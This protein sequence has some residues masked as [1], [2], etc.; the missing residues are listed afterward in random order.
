MS[1]CVW[2]PP[3]WGPPYFQYAVHH[4]LPRLGRTLLSCQNS[5]LQWL[6]RSA[7][8]VGPGPN[9]GQDKFS[10][11]ATTSTYRQHENSCSRNQYAHQY[12]STRPSCCPSTAVWQQTSRHGAVISDDKDIMPLPPGTD[13]GRDVSTP[14]PRNPPVDANGMPCVWIS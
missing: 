12:V 8:V 3:Q 10:L 4:T 13:E 9:F 2:G 6:R 1:L 5:Y 7:C 11:A 14:A